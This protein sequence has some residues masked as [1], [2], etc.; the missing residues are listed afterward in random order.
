MPSGGFMKNA[1]LTIRE[2]EIVLVKNK[3]I[4]LFASMVSLE[5]GKAVVNGRIVLANQKK[6]IF[7]TDT[8]FKGALRSEFLLACQTIAAYYG[9]DVFTHKINLVP[10]VKKSS[11]LQQTPFYA[12]N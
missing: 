12:L 6:M 10:Q 7:S 11:S 2:F 4:D 1:Y 3:Q 9:A 5:N 8:N